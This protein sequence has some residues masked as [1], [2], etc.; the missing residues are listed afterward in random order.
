MRVAVSAARREE[1]IPSKNFARTHPRLRFIFEG[2]FA[3]I[4]DATRAPTAKCHHRQLTNS[5]GAPRLMR[6]ERRNLPVQC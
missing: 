1:N 5:T 3:F 6:M 2:S 4:P